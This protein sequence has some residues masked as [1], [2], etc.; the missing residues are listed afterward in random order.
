[1]KRTI[2]LILCTVLL[3]SLFAGC[4][5]EEAPAETQ[6]SITSFSVGFAR[7]DIT[8]Q[9]PVTLTGFGSAIENRVSQNVLD[10]LSASCIAFADPEGTTILLFCID[11]IS[12]SSTV[13]SP[14]R[15]SISEAT[16]V[17]FENI[18]FTASHTHAAT[19]TLATGDPAVEAANKRMGE[20]CVTAAKEA[21]ADLK[22]AQM[23]F[24]FLRPE[25]TM[26]CS[27]HYVLKNGIFTGDKSSYNDMAAS[28]FYSH[29]TKT[30]D[31]L[32]LVK[33]T[34]EGGKDVIMVNWQGHYAARMNTIAYSITADYPG[35]IR[36]ELEN[37][38]DC[39]AAF[40]L[41]ASGNMTTG[42]RI[43]GEIY[44]PDYA[45]YGEALSKYVLRATENFTPA[46]VGNIYT[47]EVI[48]H[49]EANSHI[50]V[51]VYAFGFGDFAVITA[52]FESFDSNAQYV[53]E[54]SKF[55]YTFYA[56]CAQ[57]SLSYLPAKYVY[58]Y[59][60]PGYEAGI[61]KFG[62]G[63]GEELAEVQ[64][65]M[66]DD[67]FAA[68]GSAVQEKAEGYVEPEFVPATDGVT[69]TNPAPGKMSFFTPVE[70]GYYSCTMVTDKGTKYL[71]IENKELAEQICQTKEPMQFLF[72]EQ[73]I[74]VGIVQ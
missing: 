32:Q 59:N 20:N 36:N 50:D 10:S 73:K 31:L 63:A 7:A 70:N 34:R 16:G 58:D 47:K 17:P 2:T 46:N 42:S 28:E 6:P 13:F 64:L 23:S 27:R 5:G 19:S 41:G 74:I 26:N 53:R 43:S 1:M 44:S 18:I 37:N 40:V 57:D 24:S 12:C 38:L 60:I 30:D 29:T 14:I 8:P 9:D 35:V 54:N 65:K 72:N 39:H 48:H 11:I 69:Y 52:P 68:S 33:F 51:P 22:P 55:K 21:I 45:E 67:I 49:Y 71:L 66:L 25:E 4:G 56:S 3:L 61:N 15:Q 62:M